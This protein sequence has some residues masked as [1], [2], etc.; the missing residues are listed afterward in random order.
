MAK[1]N[2][3]MLQKLRCGLEILTLMSY[4]FLENTYN[5][6]KTVFSGKGTSGEDRI[7]AV[8][9]VFA[10]LVIGGLLGFAAVFTIVGPVSMLG[11][12][13]ESYDSGDGNILTGAFKKS[14]DAGKS[15]IAGFYKD[16]HKDIVF[17]SLG[18]DQKGIFHDQSLAAQAVNITQATASSFKRVAESSQHAANDMTKKFGNMANWV[19]ETVNQWFGK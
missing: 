5:Q 16:I 7:Y 4:A 1:E 2:K 17:Q 14:F 13:Y 9:K 10:S 12:M 11:R 8:A 3:D 18:M 15:N 6:M 19:G